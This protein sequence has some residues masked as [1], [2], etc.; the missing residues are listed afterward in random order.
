MKNL[1]PLLSRASSKGKPWEDKRENDR[2]KYQ[3]DLKRCSNVYLEDSLEMIWNDTVDGQDPAPL[4]DAWNPLITGYLPWWLDLRL[5]PYRLG[6]SL[7]SSYRIVGARFK[8]HKD[9]WGT[10]D[11]VWTLIRMVPDAWKWITISIPDTVKSLPQH[12]KILPNIIV[13]R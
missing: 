7:L 11:L 6:S 5:K 12:Q 1:R 13:E 9:C 10:L 4:W 2:S 8:D 3:L